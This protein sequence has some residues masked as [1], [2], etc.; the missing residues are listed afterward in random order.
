MLDA[1]QLPNRVIWIIIITFVGAAAIVG[2]TLFSVIHKGPAASGYEACI[3]AGNP[4]TQSFPQT[5]K[6]GE[7]IF[8][9]SEQLK[10]Q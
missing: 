7:Q 3:K 4:T 9:N 2:L 5:C 10:A 1:R 6:S 8:I